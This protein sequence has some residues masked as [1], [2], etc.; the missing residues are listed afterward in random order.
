MTDNLIVRRL[1]RI[2]QALKN[3]GDATDNIIETLPEGI[4]GYDDL[5]SL[6]ND[7]LE[8]TTQAERAANCALDKLYRM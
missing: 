3:I 5:Q 2:W 8:H 1:E 6:L 7:L 4:K